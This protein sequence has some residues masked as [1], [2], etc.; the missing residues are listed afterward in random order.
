MLAGYRRRFRWLFVALVVLSVAL[1]GVG[2]SKAPTEKTAA[3]ANFDPT[4]LVIARDMPQTIDPAVAND[5]ASGVPMRGMYETLVGYKGSGTSELEGVLAESW[6]ISTDGLKY[7]FKLRQGVKFHDGTDFNADAVKFSFERVMKINQGPADIFSSVKS[8]NVIDPYTVEIVLKNPYAPFIYALASQVGPLIVS[9]TAVKAN[10]VNGDQGQAWLTNHEAGTGPYT[11]SEWVPEQQ[12]TMTRFPDYWKGW[13]G[14]HL[15][16]I[17][18]KNVV[19]PATERMMLE[20]GDVDIA[21]FTSQ[22]D[23]ATFKTNPDLNLV[24]QPSLN[25]LYVVMNVSKGPLK[26]LKARQAVGMAFDYQSVLKDVLMG[27]GSDL[28][29]V[30]PSNLW[31][32]A[33]DLPA[34]TYD[35]EQAK[36]LAQEGGLTSGTTLKYL[37]VTG[38]EYERRVGEVLQ[39]GLQQ[40]GVK[41]EITPMTWSTLY[42]AMSDKSTAPDMYGFYW[43]P[44]IADP[45]NWLYIMFHAKSQGN[46]GYNDGYYSNTTVNNLL[47]QARKETDQTKRTE[48]YQQVQKQLVADAVAVPVAQLEDVIPMRAWVKGFTFN[49]MYI[50]TFNFYD[51]SKSVGQ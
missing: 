31:G 5:V 15:D 16:K 6:T 20:K 41:L 45:D 51:M 48:L 7:T 10:E 32:Y 1:G 40:L 24:V 19:E 28:R 9:P 8:V 26:N 30:L 33:S 27:Y 35:I 18:I 34:N 46:R 36:A 42:A 21:Q 12:I 43:Y 4:T 25:T 29:G 17:L 38:D 37:Y 22:D 49:P 47:D 13:S 2:C 23:W 3:P 14:D 11:L 50:D 39:A 44:R